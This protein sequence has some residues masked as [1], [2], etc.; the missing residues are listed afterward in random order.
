[1]CEVRGD[2]NWNIPAA[3]WEWFDRKW[4]MKHNLIVI[5]VSWLPIVAYIESYA[6]GAFNKLKK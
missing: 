5:R 1:M 3:L 2:N 6:G 4:G